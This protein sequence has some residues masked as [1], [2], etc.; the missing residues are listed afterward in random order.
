[1]TTNTENQLDL[2]RSRFTT[3]NE[4]GRPTLKT[5]AGHFT[6]S[7]T[8]GLFYVEDGVSEYHG[9]IGDVWLETVEEFD[10]FISEYLD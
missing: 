3:S 6:L 7:K 4:G 1:M 2:I 5:R 9:T 8:D 10:A